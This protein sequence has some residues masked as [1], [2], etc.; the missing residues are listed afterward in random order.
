MGNRPPG[1]LEA[2]MVDLAGS[3]QIIK[4][5]QQGGILSLELGNGPTHVN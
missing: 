1:V 5:G 2:A 3:S 4:P